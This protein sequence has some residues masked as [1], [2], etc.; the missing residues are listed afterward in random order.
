MH[1]E[2]LRVPLHKEQECCNDQRVLRRL[3]RRFPR[4]GASRR[5][6]RIY[7]VTWRER[8]ECGHMPSLI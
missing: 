6:V 1:D 5:W 7:D 8:V 4:R 2:L 3:T